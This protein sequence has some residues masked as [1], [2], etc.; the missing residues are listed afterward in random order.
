MRNA[1]ARPVGG[2]AL[3]V[4]LP[5]LFVLFGAVGAIFAPVALA[6]P[7]HWP[8][9]PAGWEGRMLDERDTAPYL[10][11]HQ[12]AAAKQSSQRILDSGERTTPN[13]DAYDAL[14]YDLHL[15]LNPTNRILTG[16]VAAKARVLSGPIA[17]LDL[18]LDNIMTVSAVTAGG[19]PASYTHVNDILTITLDRAYATGETVDVAVTYSGNPATGGAWGWDSHLGQPMIW[20]LSEPFGARTWWPCKDWSHDKADSV[21]IEV[22]APT[23]MITASNG[24][25]VFHTD[26]GMTAVDRWEHRYAIAT[27]LVSLTTHPFSVVTDYYHYAPGDSMPIQF[28]IWPDDVNEVA[29]VHAKVKTM[30]AGY[31]TY[32]GEYP[33]LEEKYGHAQFPWGGGMEHQTC[34]SL[35]YFGESVVAHELAHQ[36]WGDMVTC[37]DFHHIWLNEGFATFSEAIWSEVN[38]GI[39]A[40]HADINMNQY[41]GPGTIYVPDL[42]DWNRI[43]DGNLSYNKASWVVHMLRHVLGDED[44]FA[45]L[46]AFRV[47]YGFDSAVTEQ[48]R[49]VCETV[50]GKDLD[51]FF[52]Q[53]IYGE[54]YPQYSYT[55][56]V[57]PVA[58]GYDVLLTLEQTQPWQ[59]FTMPVDV[60][61]STAS[62]EQTF[63]VINDAASQ[64][65]VLHVDEVPTG[66]EIDKDNWI[67]KTVQDP[68][69][70]P[71]FDRS[72]LV[73]NGVDWDAYGNEIVSAY[74]DKAFWGD[75]TIDF[76][77]HFNEPASGYPATL[78]DPVGRGR[79]P[80]SI[81]G[82][83]R[84]VIWVGNNYNGDLASWL[85]S[86]ILSYLEAG[87]NLILLTRN[88]DQF[89]GDALRNYAGITWT[90]GTTINDCITNYP[91]LI[92][93]RRLGS[94]TFC[95]LFDMTLTQ[96]DSRL[97]FRAVQG[98]NPNRGV[99]VWRK[100]MGGGTYR[101]NGAQ[102]VFLSGRP[103]RWNHDDLKF[104]IMYMLENFFQEPVNPASVDNAP[105]GARVLLDPVTPNPARDGA[106]LRFRLP[107][108][109]D[110]RLSIVD[111]AGRRVR[112]LASGR[113]AAGVHTVLWDG[114]DDAGR[115]LP[116]GAYW[117]RLSAGGV[118]RSERITLV[119]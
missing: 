34:T 48:F 91:G 53:W 18:D 75:Y 13:Q 36:W 70:N 19:G 4:A 113:A 38:G 6:A 56:A 1:S 57:N 94:Q 21:F 10:S 59:I 110:V 114:R 82:R 28:F 8:A 98:Y 41:F 86:P 89:L 73:V 58:S 95:P 22:S 97:L 14:F 60:T 64:D 42:N 90:T 104:D 62:G 108:A 83:Y 45:S 50:S 74:N 99:G 43:F 77:D 32:Y 24:R 23:G 5:V 103:Y 30:I 11:F 88:G 72:V 118:E 101:P 87:G 111:L 54:Y 9:T 31:K 105:T 66:V 76:W 20:T 7:V 35:G 65:F 93:I 67:L 12:A 109:G 92:T 3:G 46:A 102:L 49:D 40:Y 15:A 68:V 52:Q 119:R 115:R 37:A 39:D 29:E 16:T 2:T 116:A 96:P 47:Q 33:F 55:Y 84:N 17:T 78:P 51:S 85:N 100:P 81:L 107:G 25:Q 112:G 44:F 61:I 69:V 79:V 80:G 106:S 26:N 71:P 117:A 63:V 27:Y